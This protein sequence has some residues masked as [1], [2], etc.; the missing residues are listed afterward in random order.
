MALRE[1]Q[2]IQT[3]VVDDFPFPKEGFFENVVREALSVPLLPEDVILSTYPKCGTTWAQFIIWGIVNDGQVPPDVNLMMFKEFP[4]LEMAGVKALEGKT[5]PR[6]IKMHVPYRLI[7]K[8]T[9]AKYIC[10]MRNPFDCCTSYYNH[11]NEIDAKLV[12]A[13]LNFEGYFEDFIRGVVPFGDYFDLVQSWYERR[14]D[15]NVLFLTYEDMK[16]DSRDEVLKIAEFLGTEYRDKLEKDPEML[17]NVLKHSSFEYMK[18]KKPF[19]II[20]DVQNLVDLGPEFALKSYS[21]PQF[22]MDENIF[23][24][25]RFYREGTVGGAKQEL[26]PEQYQKIDSQI[27]VKIKYPELRN[28]MRRTKV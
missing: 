12:R 3:L 25:P 2:H 4:F 6:L 18:E 13:T 5:S 23:F 22:Y 27:D 28:L 1:L 16:A 7:P 10:V 17:S 8:S 14:D 24:S 11:L 19:R 20:K 15:P 9:K 26:T 21:D